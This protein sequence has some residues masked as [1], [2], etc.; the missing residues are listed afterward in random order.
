MDYIFSDRASNYTDGIK[1]QQKD[2]ISFLDSLVVGDKKVVVTFDALVKD[3]SYDK[4]LYCLNS[5]NLY[6]FKNTVIDW[7]DHTVFISHYKETAEELRS[8]GLNAYFVKMGIDLSRLPEPKK[9]NGKFIY[10]GN[11]YHDKIDTYN[12]L[13]DSLD[14][15]T[16]SFNKFNDYNFTLSHEGSLEIVN[17]YSYGIGVGKCAMEM[18]G[19]GMPVLVAGRNLGGTFCTEEDYKFHIQSNTN[20]DI[21]NS[22]GLEEDIKKITEPLNTIDKSLLTFD[23]Q[24]WLKIISDN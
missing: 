14:F 5:T 22:R 15:D 16:L 12:D 9:G 7:R 11:L 23:K 17:E 13:K 24:E 1:T 18:A 2:L 19:M 21:S 10:F 3:E 20:S 8:L 6:M 4:V